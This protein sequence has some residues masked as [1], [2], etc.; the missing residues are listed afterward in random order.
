[1]RRPRAARFV[2]HPPHRLGEG[3]HEAGDLAQLGD[4]RVAIDRR[5]AEAGAQRVVM[6]GD[7]GRAAA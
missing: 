7:A 5:L 6:R 4:Q 2:E 1:M 3:Q